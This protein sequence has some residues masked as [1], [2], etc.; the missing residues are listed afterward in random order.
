MS[1]MNKVSSFK[2]EITKIWTIW[3]QCALKDT[4]KKPRGVPNNIQLTQHT[5]LQTRPRKRVWARSNSRNRLIDLISRMSTSTQQ[6]S[7]SQLQML[8]KPHLWDRSLPSSRVLWSH[9][10]RFFRVTRRIAW[11]PSG[12]RK[13]PLSEERRII[14]EAI[15]LLDRSTILESRWAPTRSLR[16]STKWRYAPRL[17]E[18]SDRSQLSK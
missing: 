6:W 4:P 17:R 11:Y 7:Q 3:H 14:Q 16:I 18:W 8:D 10:L 9:T 13:V 1:R 5:C 12:L 2:Q 15:V